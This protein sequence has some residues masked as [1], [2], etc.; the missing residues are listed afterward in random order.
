[1]ANSSLV[2]AGERK[3]VQHI[4]GSKELLRKVRGN[5]GGGGLSCPS[6][7]V[8]E[9]EWGAAIWQPKLCCTTLPLSHAPAKLLRP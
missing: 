6:A 8:G 2:P 3:K 7:G 9:W 4:R 5:G 1:M